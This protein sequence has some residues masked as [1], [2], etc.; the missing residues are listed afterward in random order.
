MRHCYTLVAMFFSWSLYAAVPV[1]V[2]QASVNV[3]LPTNSCEVTLDPAW[4]DG[5]SYDPDGSPFSLSLNNAGPYTIGTYTV[6][7]YVY[8][9][10]GLNWC[11]STYPEVQ[12]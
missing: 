11:F 12:L 4:I 5:G 2:C 1:A 7:L 8:D 10:T 6:R 9:G 3:A